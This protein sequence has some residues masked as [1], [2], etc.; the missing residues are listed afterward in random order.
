MENNLCLIL[1]DVKRDP[2][3]STT[4]FLC[5]ELFVSHVGLL[6]QISV[7][8]VIDD[9]YICIIDYFRWNLFTTTPNSVCILRKRSKSQTITIVKSVSRL[10]P[11][12]FVRCM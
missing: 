4:T 6:I 5:I 8:N 7:K 10:T 9:T 1:N 3:A 2:I 11:Y 12:D